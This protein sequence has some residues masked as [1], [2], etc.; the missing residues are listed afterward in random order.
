[1]SGMR[2]LAVTSWGGACGI[3]NYCDLLKGAIGPL[4]VPVLPDA[5]LLDPGLLDDT[6]R[7]FYPQLPEVL[8]LNYHAGLHSRWTPEMVRLVR[9]AYPQLPIVIT[10]HDTYDGQV[11]PNSENAKQLAQLADAFIVHEPTADIPEAQVIRQGIP[12]PQ[13]HFS[14]RDGAYP[15]QPMLGTAG[16]DF[17]WK[18]YTRLAELTAEIGWRFLCVSNDITP[19]RQ[20]QLHA[21]N[22]HTLVATGFLPTE[23]I[24]SYLAACTATA[25]MYETHNTGTSGAIRLGLAALRP[26]FAFRHCRQFRDL[27]GLPFNAVEW[28]DTWADLKTY[29]TCSDWS[30]GAVAGS[31]V[32]L[33][34]TDSWD[35]QAKKYQAV[36]EAAMAKRAGVRA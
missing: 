25:W 36:F 6:F 20:V 4:G 32:A 3:A 2:V 5:K 18:N 17:P 11:S 33:Y 8:W 15:G 7:R 30:P 34:A 22:P 28:V 14:F 9:E 1:M 35:Q 31:S 21:I 10:Y 13:Q 27:L 24:V 16:F 23:T 26:C 12:K 19:E 29:L